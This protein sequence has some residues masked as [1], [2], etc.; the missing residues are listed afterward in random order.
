M[1]NRS[2]QQLG[3]YT[4]LQLLGTGGF[5]EVYLGEHIYLKRKAA[6]KVLH[7]T[8][9]EDNIA[10]FLT[11]ARTI[12]NLEHPHIVR[13][14]DFGV[15]Q[16]VPYLVM[17]YAPGGTLR[18][19]HPQ[20]SRLPLSLVVS[21]VRQVAEALQYAHDA[22][23]IH[24]D[25]KPENMLVDRQ[26]QIVL[27]DFGIAL[28]SQ[29][30]RSHTAQEIAGTAAYMAP[31]QFQGNARR[32]SDQYAL[33]VV[34]YEWLCGSRPFTGT[35]TEIASQHLFTQPPPLREKLPD[36]PSEIEQVIWTALAK[37]PERRFGNI[38][39]FATA[40]EKASKTGAAHIAEPTIH[41][42]GQ[43]SATREASPGLTN[44][45]RL[46]F[47]PTPSQ[48]VPVPPTLA[49]LPVSGRDILPSLS[50]PVAPP[51]APG[52]TPHTEQPGGEKAAQRGLS[53]RALIGSMIGGILGIAAIAGGVNWLLRPPANLL[54]T[55]SGGS[56]SG[57][58][59]SPDGKYIV[60]S[61]SKYITDK[62]VQVW[63]TSTGATIFTYTGHKTNVEAVAWSPD[64]KRIASAD[65]TTIQVWDATTGGNAISYANGL[66][67]PNGLTWSPNSRYI[68]SAGWDVIDVTVNGDSISAHPDPMAHWAVWVWDA[69]SGNTILSYDKHQQTG[70]AGAVAWSPD[71]R[72][73]ASGDHDNDNTVR[74]SEATTGAL[75]VQYKKHPSGSMI[76]V[77]AWSPNG[78]Y[79]ASG[80]QGGG[81]QVWNATTGTTIFIS[82]KD[83]Q[84]LA[85]SPDGKRIV[86]GSIFSNEVQVWDATTGTNVT[87]YNGH[88]Q[89][90]YVAWSSDGKRLALGWQES[91]QIWRV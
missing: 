5:A 46:A 23:L 78:K 81:T 3:H 44:D 31:E 54:S 6:I 85:W 56:A 18:R 41:P 33:A 87:T 24:R 49:A 30:S 45:T 39:A 86:A 89:V 90:G 8:L 10:P 79:I 51:L 59:W 74:V 7:T 55:Y 4:L 67:S 22:R 71:G 61:N 12:A 20:G 29:S 9:A 82:G 40:L 1:V 69:V 35:F 88:S 75:V 64:G 11:E 26:Q 36:L 17:D 2:G 70:T 14:L 21:Y 65:H 58:A 28:M 50:T 34:I 73:I 83:A 76:E 47:P 15:E 13:V 37:D 42:S 43:L 80:G 48:P 32:A 38:R 63:D 84:T 66:Y 53:R 57:I 16:H 62:T 52:H 77:V 72:Y 19:R 27:S 68:A 91:I 60:S 25:I